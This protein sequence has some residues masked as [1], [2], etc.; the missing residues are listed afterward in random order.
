MHSEPNSPPDTLPSETLAPGPSGRTLEQ[1]LKQQGFQGSLASDLSRRIVASTDN[2][3]YQMVPRRVATA[4]CTEDLGRLVRALRSMPSPPPIVA[5]GGGTGTNGQSLT[6]DLLVDCS[7][8]RRVLSVDVQAR[9]AWVEPGVVLDDL[10]RALAP[11]DL[12]FAPHVSTSS[13]A[14][15][16]GMVSTDAAGKGSRIYGRTSDHVTALRVVLP[17]GSEHELRPLS[18]SEARRLAASGDGLGPLLRRL[19][20]SLDGQKDLIEQQSPRLERGFS[21]YN[22][23]KAVGSDTFDPVALLC[24]SEGTLALITAVEVHLTPRPAHKAL[25]VVDYDDFTSALDDVPELL[26]ADPAAIEA[27]DEWIQSLGRGSAA[28]QALKDVLPQDAG[29]SLFVELVDDDLDALD[30]RLEDFER[31]LANHGP[32]CQ[33]TV[34]R[35]PELQRQ[36]WAL[37]KNTVGLLAKG[38]SAGARPTAFVEDC[39][40]PVENLS[41][42]IAEF[43]ELLDDAGLEYGIYGHADAGCVHVR[44]ALDLSHSDRGRRELRRLSDRVETITRRHGG[45]LWGEHGIGLRGEYLEQR[46]G[47]ELYELMVAVKRAF[48]PDGLLNPHKLYPSRAETPIHALDAAPL[49]A[50]RDEQVPS[51]QRRDFADAFRCNGNGA[52][53]R[54]A[55]EG[56]MCPSFQA[57]DDYRQSPKG[58]SDLLREWLRR[59][60]LGEQDPQLTADLKSSLDGCLS[61][62][63][64]TSRCPA[65]VDIPELKSRFLEA[66]HRSTR[67]P[68]REHLMARL[69]ALGPRLAPWARWINPLMHNP[70]SRALTKALGLVDLPRFSSPP[71]VHRLEQRQARLWHPDELSAAVDSVSLGPKTVILLVDPFTALF[72]AAV[73]V[74]TWDLIRKLGFEPLAVRL[75]P[76][77]KFEH[78]K[79]MRRRFQHAAEAQITA[80]TSLGSRLEE[81][82]DGSVPFVMVEPSVALMFEQEYRDH[83]AVTGNLQVQALQ[84]WLL[85]I[86]L[87]LPTPSRAGKES[88]QLLGHCSERAADPGSGGT[89]RRV[90]SRFGVELETPAVGCCGMAGV[91]GHEAENQAVSRRLFDLSWRPK[92]QSPDPQDPEQISLATGFSCRCQSAHLI[93]RRPM[94]PAEFLVLHLASISTPPSIGD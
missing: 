89:W 92:L 51:E 4:S 46:L 38:G 12:F 85:D 64:C 7:G 19:L 41:A 18:W 47:P 80:L 54:R 23:R 50:D 5:R 15:L 30:G 74:A 34:L 27:M 69:E 33:A 63:A 2:S 87:E 39:A 17:D 24:G 72:D 44:P 6:E 31:F 68:L 53:H 62:K 37:R 52:C 73:P 82:L 58:R 55:P 13:R 1:H 67:R 16:G 71:L 76:T 81:R 77:G 14:T 9:R 21:G 45:V 57:T 35:D 43:R 3:I 40:V 48:D 32:V 22:L 10:N 28:W 42:F 83:V 66:H 59:Q 65:E 90:F 49:R 78:V 70:L 60:A 11:H 88:V 26:R 93:G 36:V 94:H 91:F 79:G 56:I 86:P 29:S 25:V 20:N 84:D 61:C 8:L 75:L